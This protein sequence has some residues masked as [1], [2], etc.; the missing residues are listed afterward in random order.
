MSVNEDVVP[1]LSKGRRAT[2]KHYLDSLQ[3]TVFKPA[4]TLEDE[5]DAVEYASAATD[6]FLD[7][8][9]G[10]LAEQGWTPL[11]IAERLGLEIVGQRVREDKFRV[12]DLSNATVTM[13]VDTVG[14]IRKE[15]S[16]LKLLDKMYGAA[17]K[18]RWPTTPFK[19]KDDET[20][21]EIVLERDDTEA[22]GEEFVAKKISFEQ[23]RIS[24]DQVR[25]V[26]KP[27]PSLLRKCEVNLPIT[28]VRFNAKPAKSAGLPKKV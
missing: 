7:E 13:L 6:D 22:G 2:V 18:A 28:Q 12:P 26:L 25:E 27:W 19:V 3:V 9:L 11:Q 10:V 16:S 8:V 4:P 1:L 17:L 23:T 21:E 14:N 20:Q 24:P 5:I 15:M